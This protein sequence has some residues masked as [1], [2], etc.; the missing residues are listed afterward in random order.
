MP[1]G[2]ALWE[3][4]RRGPRKTGFR[5][6]APARS[7]VREDSPEALAHHSGPWS[8]ADLPRKIT[9]I[10]IQVEKD[11]QTFFFH[12]LPTRGI[13]YTAMLMPVKRIPARLLP[14]LPLF[15][16]AFSLETGTAK[17]RLRLIPECAW[18]LKQRNRRGHHPFG[19]TF[20]GRQ[21]YCWLSIAG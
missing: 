8:V 4:R 3:G 10:P 14:M 12:D 19:E 20:S 13:A 15:C 7:P 6:R 1:S 18:R 21:A 11:E 17:E 16:R 9:R 2:R 5:N